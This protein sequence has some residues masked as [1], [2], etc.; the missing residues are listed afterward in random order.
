MPAGGM[1]VMYPLE[2]EGDFVT[3]ADVL[4]GWEKFLK[5]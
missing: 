3:Y 5:E 1:T 2:P 4:D